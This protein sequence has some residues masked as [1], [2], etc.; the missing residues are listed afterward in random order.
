MITPFDILDEAKAL[1]DLPPETRTEARR[2]TIIG[3]CYYAAYQHLSS[4]EIA[5]DYCRTPGQNV[6][7]HKSFLDYLKR[8]KRPDV[9]NAVRVLEFLRRWRTTADYHLKDSIDDALEET[10]WNQANKLMSEILPPA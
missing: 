3:R 6:G 5:K 1:L 8:V 4:H 7:M 10:C 9:Y 2:R